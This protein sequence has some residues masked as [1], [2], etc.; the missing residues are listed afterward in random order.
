MEGY[1]Y[2]NKTKCAERGV[3]EIPTITGLPANAWRE[4]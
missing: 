4:A 2:W 3:Q 1:E